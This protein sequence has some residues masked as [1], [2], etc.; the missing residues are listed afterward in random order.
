MW[1]CHWLF[2]WSPRKRHFGCFQFLTI[3]NNTAI[4]ISRWFTWMLPLF[5]VCFAFVISMERF[6]LIVLPNPNP[7]YHR[8]ERALL[9]PWLT[10]F[11]ALFIPGRP[12][13]IGS[14]RVGHDW[15]HIHN[16]SLLPIYSYSFSQASVLIFLMCIFS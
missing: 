10:C 13:S 8:S 7:F 2:I 11:L 15:T 12:Q 3:K 9:L 16:R 6:E 1:I 5:L 14:Q 4:N